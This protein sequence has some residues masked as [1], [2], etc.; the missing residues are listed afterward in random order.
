MLAPR[1]QSVPEAAESFWEPTLTRGT[2]SGSLGHDPLVK[3]SLTDPSHPVVHP[4]VGRVF[5]WPYVP[6]R[7]QKLS[8]TWTV[9]HLSRTSA[10]SGTSNLVT[11]VGVKELSGILMDRGST[12]FAGRSGRVCWIAP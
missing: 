1:R 12:L 8:V 5:S 2:P 3:G 11:T 6:P 9:G 4:V 10:H 7:R